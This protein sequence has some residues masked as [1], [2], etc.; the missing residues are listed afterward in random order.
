LLYEIEDH[1]LLCA[2]SPKSNGS[3]GGT[4][5]KGAASPTPTTH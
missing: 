4:K 2:E 3:S 5:P 1:E